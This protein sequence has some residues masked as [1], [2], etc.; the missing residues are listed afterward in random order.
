MDPEQQ[1]HYSRAAMMHVS[2]QTAAGSGPLNDSASAHELALAELIDARL[3]AAVERV[4]LLGALFQVILR[5]CAA[6]FY[7][8]DKRHVMTPSSPV[9]DCVSNLVDIAAVILRELKSGDLSYRESTVC[10][11]VSAEDG[12]EGMDVLEIPIHVM[13]E[14]MQATAVSALAR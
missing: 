3:Q 5:Q 7:T 14:R 4:K 1:Q 2:K 11:Q 9:I 12:S 13:V 10:F 8:H 6:T